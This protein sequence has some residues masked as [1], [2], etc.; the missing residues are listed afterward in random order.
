VQLGLVDPLDAERTNLLIGA[1]REG[2]LNVE[3]HAGAS[4]VVVSIGPVDGGVQV[5]VADD[6]GPPGEDAVECPDGAGLGVRMLAERA[7]RLGGR[8]SLVHDED[9][10]TTLRM[11][12]PG[13]AR[14]EP[15]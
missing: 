10:G 1:V 5:A 15:R 13:P 6:G 12:L 8:V 7:A 9:G 11:L 4:T 3:K 14:V 2:L